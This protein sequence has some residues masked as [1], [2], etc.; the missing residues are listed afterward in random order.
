MAGARETTLRL[1]PELEAGTG[2]RSARDGVASGAR[3]RNE[4]AEPASGIH[5]HGALRPAHRSVRTEPAADPLAP[6][7]VGRILDGALEILGRRLGACLALSLP[8]ALFAVAG[9]DLILR[10]GMDIFGI[11]ALDATADA[12]HAFAQVFV[13]T[14]LAHV[15]LGELADRPVSAADAFIATVRRAPALIGLALLTALIVGSELVIGWCACFVP[16]FILLAAFGNVSSLS[17]HVWPIAS[18]GAAF[19]GERLGPARSLGRAIGLSR[20]RPAFLR[21]AGW[22][23][24]L[25]L[26]LAPIA[27]ARGTLAQPAAREQLV[28]IPFLSSVLV[29]VLFAGVGALLVGLSSAIAGL[30]AAVF[31][32][33]LCV[34]AEGFDLELRLARLAEAG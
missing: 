26:V 8:P 13:A 4:R 33:D 30:T 17:P 18:A 15:A 12:L 10:S 20:G 9:I 3:A 28:H 14:A 7:G 22:F 24:V 31:H 2:E 5:A 25:L 16:G 6:R 21:W 34:R 23:L 29:D 1:A 27:I 19:A 11:F 32:V